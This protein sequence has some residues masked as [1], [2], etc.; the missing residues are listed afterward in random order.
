MALESG[1]ENRKGLTTLQVPIESVC[2]QMSTNQENVSYLPGSESGEGVL[3]C[4]NYE[5]FF[6]G[7]PPRS[8]ILNEQRPQIVLLPLKIKLFTHDID[9]THT[10][11][12]SCKHVML[13]GSCKC[14]VT[15]YYPPV[16][17]VVTDGP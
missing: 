5:P 10:K 15:C 16:H 6:F 7:P 4:M 12:M 2:F 17:V 3:F 11:S 13:L 1:Q 8:S 9:N 14:L